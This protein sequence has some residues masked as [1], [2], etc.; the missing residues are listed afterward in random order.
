MSRSHSQVLF[1]LFAVVATGCAQQGSS[2]GSTEQLAAAPAVAPADLIPY[3]FSGGSGSASYTAKGKDGTCSGTLTFNDNVIYVDVKANGDVDP[4]ILAAATLT[5]S[6]TCKGEPFELPEVFDLKTGS[7]KSEV[8]HDVEGAPPDASIYGSFKMS[9]PVCDATIH[10]GRWIAASG[11]SRVQIDAM[12][13][14]HLKQTLH[15]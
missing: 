1:L 13:I 8:V 10:L 6:S 12:N 2:P 15:C 4:G 5:G 7:I 11:G 3:R 14:T 9:G